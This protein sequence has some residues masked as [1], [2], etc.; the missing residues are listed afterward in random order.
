MGSKLISVIVSLAIV[1]GLS[2]VPVMPAANVALA[3]DNVTV[4][5][6]PSLKVVGVNSSFTLDVQINNPSGFQVAMHSVRLNFSPAY[7]NI[8]NVSKVDLP[9]DMGAPAI[10]NVNG[11]MDYDPC[12]PTGSSNTNATIVSCRLTC[13]AHALQ[14]SST[15]DYVYVAA[16]PPRMTQVVNLTGDDALENGNMSLMLSGTVTIAT[17]TKCC[18]DTITGSGIVKIDGVAKGEGQCSDTGNLSNHTFNLLAEPDAGWQFAN[19]TGEVNNTTANPA[20]IF[21]PS[22]GTKN[23]SV[24]FTEKENN[25]CFDAEVLNFGTLTTTG[26]D[27]ANKTVNVSNCGGGTLNWNSNITWINRP[28]SNATIEWSPQSGSL[29]AGASE[30]IQVAVKLNNSTVAGTY[31]ANITASG[32]GADNV[33]VTFYLTSEITPERTIT[34]PRDGG[35]PCPEVVGYAYPGDSFNVNISWSTVDAVDG[36]ML[37]DNT[38]VTNA[39]GPYLWDS[40]VFIGNGTPA[41]NNA[42]LKGAGNTSVQYLWS[43]STPGST[44]MWVSYNVT[45]PVDAGPGLY[46]MTVNN[47]TDAWIEYYIGEDVFTKYIG[48]DFQI[49]V[50]KTVPV[51]GTVWEIVWKWWRDGYDNHNGT[52]TLANATVYLNGTES[53]SNTTNATG[54]YIFPAVAPGTY[55]VKASLPTAFN[56]RVWG[57]LTIIGNE[58]ETQVCTFIGNKGLLPQS[59]LYVGNQKFS[60][61]ALSYALKAVNCYVYN[62]SYPA[63]AANLTSTSMGQVVTVW[64]NTTP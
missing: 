52:L 14:G 31:T 10:D 34:L 56:D 51:E 4:S 13:Q 5:I 37:V 60:A 27:P 55:E 53:Y 25:T 59:P 30:P 40:V 17:G 63:G 32:S 57:N 61:I 11:T 12:M 64:L 54:Y 39:S 45:V 7:F 35:G 62:Q 8:T 2:L 46:N 16:P 19:W 1:L 3:L 20:T 42:T 49:C 18:V 41:P 23:I 22:G 24:N 9:N 36:M 29:G 33:T 58:N 50:A 38:S 26:G 15:V 21:V 43:N 28:D 47:T 6:E 48:G 44:P